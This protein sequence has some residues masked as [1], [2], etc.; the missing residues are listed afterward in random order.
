MQFNNRSL[1]DEIRTPIARLIG[2]DRRGGGRDHYV[3][4]VNNTRM[5]YA[6][7]RKNACTA[8]KNLIIAST[9]HEPF[10]DARGNP[11]NFLNEFHREQSFISLENCDYRLFVYRD[12][13]ERIASLFTNKLVMNKDN[14]DLLD[15]I[16]HITERDPWE[17]SFEDFIDKY[18]G[19]GPNSAA[20]DPHIWS[21]ASHLYPIKYTHAI[22]MA[23]LYNTLYK[24]IGESEANRFFAKKVNVSDGEI[25]A[26]MR[27]TYLFPVGELHRE[28]K[29]TGRRPSLKSLVSENIHERVKALYAD[30]YRLIHNIEGRNRIFKARAW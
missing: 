8:F 13:T 24:I 30:D 9:E 21:Q 20:F 15:N 11:I 12:P 1:R 19:L 16:R 14:D 7:I 22:P 6:Y 2:I 27:E 29:K 25:D 23:Y 4:N 17:F 28:W 10:F 5:A 26:L 3:F 18:I